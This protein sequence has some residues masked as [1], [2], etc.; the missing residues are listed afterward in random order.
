MNDLYLKLKHR[1]AMYLQ[2]VDMA[3]RDTE[4]SSKL[5]K[6]IKQHLKTPY[7]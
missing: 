3:W 7:I 6:K 5:K 1:S 2:I 4:I